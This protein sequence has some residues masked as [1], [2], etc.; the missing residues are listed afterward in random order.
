[1]RHDICNAAHFLDAET[2]NRRAE[3]IYPD[4][5][6]EIQLSITGLE[7]DLQILIPEFAERIVPIERRGVSANE[8]AGLVLGARPKSGIERSVV[9]IANK[10]RELITLGHYRPQFAERLIYYSTAKRRSR[11]TSYFINR[12]KVISFVGL[13][14]HHPNG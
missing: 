14:Q 7:S 9:D 4:E 1:M 12:L 8:I 3:R 13:T 6:F 11:K 5:F 10:P 2:N